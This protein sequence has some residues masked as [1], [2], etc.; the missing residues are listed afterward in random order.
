MIAEIGEWLDIVYKILTA[1][2]VVWL[3]LDRRNDKTNQRISDMELDLDHR[4]DKHAERLTRIEQDIKHV[5]SQDD[6]AE[7]YREMRKQ[8]GTMATINANVTAQAATLKSLE[9]LVNRM[10]EFWRSHG[11]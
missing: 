8:S 6:L 4:L 2:F 1:I 11:K 3:Y 10:D 7:I 9:S 5:P